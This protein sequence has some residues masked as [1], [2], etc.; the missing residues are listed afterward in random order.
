[1]FSNQLTGRIG[2]KSMQWIFMK[3]DFN[4]YDIDINFIE[5]STTTIAS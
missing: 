5:L 1:M 3:A 2:I 4:K